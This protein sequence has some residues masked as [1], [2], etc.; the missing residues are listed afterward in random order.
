MPESAQNWKAF[1]TELRR[2]LQQ[3]H[4]GIGIGISPA[5]SV[6]ELEHLHDLLHM[7]DYCCPPHEHKDPENPWTLG[8]VKFK[9]GKD[10]AEEMIKVV[11]GE[12]V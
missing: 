6:E 10:Y 12:L 8:K 9:Y 5:L 11:R 7:D 4:G 2:H 3:M 1:R